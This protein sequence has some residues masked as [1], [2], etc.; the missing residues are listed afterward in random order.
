MVKALDCGITSLNSSCT[1]TFTFGKYPW[2]RHEPRYPPIYGLNSTPTAP[3]KKKKIDLALDNP[4]RLIC[5]EIT[6]KQ[7]KMVKGYI[8]TR[9]FLLDQ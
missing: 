8:M 5:Y 4:R 7:T 1:I 6:N 9:F 2:E 3:K